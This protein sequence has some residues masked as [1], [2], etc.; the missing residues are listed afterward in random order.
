M[1]STN[2]RSFLK[3][4]SLFTGAALLP[5]HSPWC[6]PQERKTLQ[7]KLG[8]ALIGLG[9]YSTD[10]LAPAL[11]ETQNVHLAGIVTGTPAKAETWAKKYRIPQSNI[12]S[13]ETFD[14]IAD[15]KA[16]DMV[17]VV[18]PN[19]L[20]AEFTVRAAKAG[21][22]VICEKPMALSVAECEL[23]IHACRDNRVSLSIGYRMQFEPHTQE[24]MRY[25]R[26][27][28]LGAIEYV[29]A[30]AGFK[31]RSPKTHWKL[32]K[33]YGGGALMDMGVYS[34][35]GARYSIGEEPISVTAQ[36]YKT[37]PERFDQ[38]DEIVTLQLEFPGGAMA[39]L[40]TSFYTGT[41]MLYAA[42]EKGW[43]S[44]NPFSSYRGIQMSTSKGAVELPQIN[45][46]A[47]QMDEVAW[48]IANNQ[49]MRV[50]GE[51]GLRDLRIVEAVRESLRSGKKISIA[52]I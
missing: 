30:S 47:A 38:V 13:Y 5:G 26:E 15:N 4:C 37:D 46:Q 34:I 3:T 2:R 50:P 10:L 17:Y 7:R 33:A 29:N 18:L 24:L 27:K 9:Y 11:Q 52:K 42:A 35:Q 44:L 39:N 16:I 25:G 43:I 1:T 31:N 20:H 51:E 23:M 6:A 32:Q 49:P 48:C 8:I 40:M 19:S 28:V 21:K 45:Q 22:H 36:E 14:R 41:N 12:Y